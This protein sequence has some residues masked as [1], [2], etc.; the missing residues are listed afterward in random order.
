LVC[1]TLSFGVHEPFA[2]VEYVVGDSVRIFRGGEKKELGYRWVEFF[3]SVLLFV[4]PFNSV[5]KLTGDEFVMSCGLLRLARD[6]VCQLDEDGVV[7]II[8]IGR[9]WD[10]EVGW[11]P[12]WCL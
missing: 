1:N 5:V 4:V 2:A 9:E 12:R 10:S 3:E 6:A 7:W 11:W 8:C